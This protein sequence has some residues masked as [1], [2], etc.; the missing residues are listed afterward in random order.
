MA[1]AKALSDLKKRPAARE[2]TAE[3]FSNRTEGNRSHVAFFSRRRQDVATWTLQTL[4]KASLPA[5]SCDAERSVPVKEKASGNQTLK[6]Q[7]L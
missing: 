1:L 5:P 4:Q 3:P 6:P 2:M 7:W